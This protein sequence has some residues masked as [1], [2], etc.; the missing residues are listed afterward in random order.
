MVP[1]SSQKILSHLHLTSPLDVA[2]LWCHISVSINFKPGA[3]SGAH[4]YLSNFLIFLKHRN[5]CLQPI[6][7]SSWCFV[8][9]LKFCATIC[10]PKYM[11]PYIHT[12]IH[13][14]IC[15]CMHAH[16]LIQT[17]T[18]THKHTH[19]C[20]HTHACTHTYSDSH[21][22]IYTYTTLFFNFHGSQMFTH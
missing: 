8:S 13:M 12:S 17:H 6:S 11:C 20:K 10:I 1:H 5:F 19:S 3:H 18:W 9:I 2:S 22:H 21:M 15:V 14:H 7:L 4:W 16:T